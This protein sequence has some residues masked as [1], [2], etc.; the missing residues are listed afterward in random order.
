MNRLTNRLRVQRNQSSILRLCARF[1]MI[2]L[3]VVP[4]PGG[5]GK[6]DHFYHFI[7]DLLLPLFKVIS[8]APDS[9]TFLVGGLGPFGAVLERAFP[10]RV[11]VLQPRLRLNEV[12]E[13]KG[14]HSL[15]GMNPRNCFLF[16][17][18]IL[19]FRDHVVAALDAQ[20]HP[21][22]NRVL[23]IERLPPQQ[24][25]VEKGKSTSG[26]GRRSIR[27]H[28]QLLDHLGTVFGPQVDVVN[29]HLEN[30]SL[31]EQIHYF[32]SAR[33]VIAQHGA[34][35]ANIIWMQAETLVVELSSNP[36]DDHFSTLCRIMGIH[37]HLYSC[38]SDHPRIDCDHFVTW[39]QAVG[40]APDKVATR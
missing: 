24:Y 33:I 25:Y 6:P 39:L 10:G 21:A 16:R 34:A 31:C 2:Y 4:P 5:K 11:Q 30:L 22:P 8:K 1:Q 13:S 32:S 19:V 29:L 35:L 3:R 20:R 17:R 38:D 27:N 36:G 23:L 9:T 28:A 14:K 18:E 40:I 26:A 7:F 37:H 15:V 12:P